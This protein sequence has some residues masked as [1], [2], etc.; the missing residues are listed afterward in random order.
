MLIMPTTL[1][2]SITG[3]CEKPC[4]LNRFSTAPT[5]RC[6]SMVY[7]A[8]VITLLTL[9]LPHSWRTAALIMFSSVTNPKS[10]SSSNMGSCL[11]PLSII[12]FAILEISESGEILGAR[13]IKLFTLVDAGSS[14]DRKTHRLAI[15]PVYLPLASKT[16]NTGGISVLKNS[17]HLDRGSFSLTVLTPSV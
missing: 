12:S 10:F 3:T 17:R 1:P 14:L 6:A 5:D 13:R 16:A 2:A 4:S 11:V 7:G 15:T 9:F 8:R